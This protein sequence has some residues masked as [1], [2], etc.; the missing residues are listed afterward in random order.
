[1]E[2]SFTN[3]KHVVLK[4]EGDLQCHFKNIHCNN[5]IDS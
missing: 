2:I 4:K 1:M 3:M 5:K